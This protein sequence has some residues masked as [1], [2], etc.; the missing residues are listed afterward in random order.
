MEQESVAETDR[1]KAERK[2]DT[3]VPQLPDL[4]LL[5]RDGEN[6]RLSAAVLFTQ[7]K[8][9]IGSDTRHAYLNFFTRKSLL[10]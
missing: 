8:H 2:R 4:S 7:N 1:A 5:D 3:T 10:R 9:W 6:A